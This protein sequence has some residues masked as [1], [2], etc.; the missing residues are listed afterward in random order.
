M[1]ALDYFTI[2]GTLEVSEIKQV[3]KKL[4]H[5]PTNEELTEMFSSVDKDGNNEIDFEEFCKLM[6][7]KMSNDPEKELKDAF[8]VF[9]SDHSG[10][11][12]RNEL[13]QLMKK[14]GQALT[15]A[16]IDSLARGKQ[17]LSNLR[18]F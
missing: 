10:S 4:G 5:N 3:M 2:L 7:S 6:A 1:M 14:L 9:D 8:N 17:P 12:D 18:A 11:I 13:A 16:Q 15:D